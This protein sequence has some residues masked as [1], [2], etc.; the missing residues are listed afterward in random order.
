MTL[1]KL[2]KKIDSLKWYSSDE[3]I[4]Y[5]GFILIIDIGLNILKI[6]KPTNIEQIY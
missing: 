2:K 5:I 1:K 4:V 6:R 3:N